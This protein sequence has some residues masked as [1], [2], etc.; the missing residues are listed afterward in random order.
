M[1]RLPLTRPN[2]LVH[3][4]TERLRTAIVDAELH[5]GE[6]VSEEGLA[7]AFSVSR[8]PVREALNLLQMQGLIEIKPQRGSFVFRPTTEDIERLCEFR[9]MLEVSVAPLA[10]LRA[11][12]AALASLEQRLILIERAFDANDGLA[13]VTSD[14]NLHQVFF[15]HCGNNYF[16]NAYAM[17]S[18]KTAALRTNLSGNQHADQELSLGEHRQI[19]EYFR[20]NAMAPLATLL[21]SH[22]GRMRQNF[23][24]ALETGLFAPRPSPRQGYSFSLPTD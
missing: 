21:R 7:E 1:R 22:I 20:R 6:A 2:T 19:V 13:Y 18:S 16:Q 12:A 17:I 23:V 4:V 15:E 3:A 5:L 24:S 9:A 10:A 8:T 11:H 14:N